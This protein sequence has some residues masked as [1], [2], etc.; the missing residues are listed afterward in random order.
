MNIQV[1]HLLLKCLAVFTGESPS[2]AATVDNTLS[3]VGAY[4]EERLKVLVTSD[5]K[6]SGTI[7]LTPNSN[8]A[9]PAPSWIFLH[10]A[11]LLL[12][13]LK[14]ILLF[15]SFINKN[16]S[17]TSGDGKAKINA[18]KDRVK[19]VADEVRAQCQGLK[20]R[21]SSSGMLGHLVDIVH[22]RPGG[23][24]GTEDVESALTLDA[25]IEALMDSASLELFCGSLMESWEDALDGVISICS[26]VR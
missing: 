11:I 2:D 7:D 3:K 26:T 10:E 15:I 6:T 21:I 22:M 12:E 8:P 13:T 20:I 5:S 19:A 17:Y 9:S 16:K 4:L 18:L 25:E 23:L 14:A 1:H 24:T